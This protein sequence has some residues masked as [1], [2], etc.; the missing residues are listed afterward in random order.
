MTPEDELKKVNAH[1]IIFTTANSNCFVD[2]L[3]MY[4]I[5]D[6]FKRALFSITAEN[7]F[8]LDGEINGLGT[9]QSIGGNIKSQMKFYAFKYP[10]CST[11]SFSV[12]M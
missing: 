8:L 11:C 10:S 4:N 2:L 1:F 3:K 12:C 5:F 7:R 6:I 9:D